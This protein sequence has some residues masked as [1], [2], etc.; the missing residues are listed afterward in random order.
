MARVVGEHIVACPACGAEIARPAYASIHLTAREVW[1]DGTGSIHA[2]MPDGVLGRCCCGQVFRPYGLRA[3]RYEPCFP[4]TPEPRGVF[5]QLFRL[6]PERRF[7]PSSV[8]R[9]DPVADSELSHLLAGP[10]TPDVEIEARRRLWRLHNTP[11]RSDPHRS[12]CDTHPDFTSN[13]ETL[14]ALLAHRLHRGGLNWVKSIESSDDLR[15]PCRRL[16]GCQATG[17]SCL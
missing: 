10:C 2:R 7:V 5:N 15:M 11:Y 6:R 4:A 12:L 17:P 1:S 14:A 13:L 9:F 8:P 16:E 3:M